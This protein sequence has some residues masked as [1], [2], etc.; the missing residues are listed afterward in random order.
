MTGSGVEQTDKLKI[1]ICL[2]YYLPHR[3][4]MQLYI[5]RIAEELVRRGHEVTVLVARHRRDLPSDEMIKF[6]TEYEK[7]VTKYT[8]TNAK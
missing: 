2:L 6:Q 3:T 1:L 5:E 7:L 4:G 8:T